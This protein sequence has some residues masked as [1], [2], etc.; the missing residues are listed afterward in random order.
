[1]ACQPDRPAALETTSPKTSEP[2]L[3]FR[4]SFKN[5][6]SYLCVLRELSPPYR[7]GAVKRGLSN[8]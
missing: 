1:M 6:V 4:R 8:I 2:Y 7:T 5:Y 3:A